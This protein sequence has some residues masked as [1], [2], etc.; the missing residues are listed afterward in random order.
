MVIGDFTKRERR[1][2]GD[3]SEIHQL[4]MVKSDLA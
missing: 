3:P 2:G 1:F 4:H